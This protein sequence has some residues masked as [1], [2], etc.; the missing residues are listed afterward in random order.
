MYIKEVGLWDV[1]W[2]AL[3]QDRDLRERCRR[4]KEIAEGNKLHLRGRNS[5]ILEKC[6]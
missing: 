2:I 3:A 6:A 5:G 1:E 4:Y